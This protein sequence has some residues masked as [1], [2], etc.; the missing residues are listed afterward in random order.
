[1]RSRRPN[2]VDILVGQNIRIQRLA[3]EMTQTALAAQLGVTFQQL[4]KYEQGI[5]RVGS[6]RLVSIA[7]ALGVP[8]TALLNGAESAQKSDAP[9]PLALIA[10][11]QPFR[12]AS[13]FS[14]IEDKELR[15]ALVSVMERIAGLS[16]R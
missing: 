8:V 1:M 6:G 11:R 5:N 16:R 13:A 10:G 14:R 9:P 7:E 15:A 2:S 4:Q 12:L 3:R